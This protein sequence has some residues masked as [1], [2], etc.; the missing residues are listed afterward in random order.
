MSVISATSHPSKPAA[1][2]EP[3]EGWRAILN[4]VLR[5]QGSSNLALRRTSTASQNGDTLRANGV[6]SEVLDS[7]RYEGVD[8]NVEAMVEGVKARGGRDL[9][10]YVRG[11]LG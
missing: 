11:L 1:T 8:D 9:L 10:Q 2:L 7:L 4:V 5:Y 3:V 6:V